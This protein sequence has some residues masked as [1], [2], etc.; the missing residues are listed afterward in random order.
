MDWISVS[1]NEIGDDGGRAIAVYLEEGSSR[2]KELNIS[3]NPICFEGEEAICKAIAGTS[4]R[5]LIMRSPKITSTI[6]LRHSLL[7]NASLDELTLVE[8]EEDEKMFS[9]KA[10]VLGEGCAG[11]VQ[12]D[13]LRFSPL[14]FFRKLVV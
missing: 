5:S 2:L 12:L 10:R 4:I 11:A 9:A 14:S 7:L 6:S 1:H 13:L 8:E 3:F